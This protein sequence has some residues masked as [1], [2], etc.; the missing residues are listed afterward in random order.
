MTIAEPIALLVLGAVLA[1]L[2]AL[3]GYA[4]YRSVQGARIARVQRAEAERAHALIG[5]SPAMAMRVD[6]DQRVSLPLALVDRLP[7][8]RE[9]VTALLAAVQPSTDPDDEV[10]AEWVTFCDKWGYG[11]EQREAIRSQLASRVLGE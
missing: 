5:H 3:A 9:S 8:L 6:P 4:F 11:A 10:T 7:G 1:I 2:V